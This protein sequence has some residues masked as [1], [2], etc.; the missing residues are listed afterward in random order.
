MGGQVKPRKLSRDSAHR[1]SLLRNMATS[2]IEHESITTTW[3]KA[4]EAQRFTEKLITLGKKNTEGSRR[5]AQ[6]MLFVRILYTYPTFFK[7]C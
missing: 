3:P 2:L 6:G 4:K 1:K 7:P 5:R